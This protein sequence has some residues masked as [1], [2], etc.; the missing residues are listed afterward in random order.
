MSEIK[1]NNGNIPMV[2]CK[3]EKD[4]PKSLIFD[5]LNLLKVLSVEAPISVGD[6][7]LENVCDTGINIVSTRTVELL[8]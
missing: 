2:P 1:V 6:I 4:I 8:K 3:T 7:L 5:V